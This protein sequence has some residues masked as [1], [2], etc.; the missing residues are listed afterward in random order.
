MSEDNE[1]IQ[2]PKGYAGSN[3]VLGVF[4]KSLLILS[5]FHY[6]M[7]DNREPSE[8]DDIR[9]PLAE[10]LRKMRKDRYPE[11][12]QYDKTGGDIRDL[13]TASTIDPDLSEADTDPRRRHLSLHTLRRTASDFYQRNRKGIIK[14]FGYGGA[15]GVALGCLYVG[16]LS[17]AKARKEEEV[18]NTFISAINEDLAKIYDL[19][20]PYCPN[21]EMEGKWN[22]ELI[23]RNQ[24]VKNL[25]IRRSKPICQTLAEDIRD[26]FDGVW[27]KEGIT[28]LNDGTYKVAITFKKP[29]KPLN[30]YTTHK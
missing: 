14:F 28:G 21:G 20:T 23:V 12:D 25:V 7:S 2:F 1:E 9:I 29:Q 13:G 22:L 8:E 11:T 6:L 18:R 16:T 26:Y 30:N 4:N 5:L 27:K 3:P 19:D 10:A 24:G 15:T 17:L